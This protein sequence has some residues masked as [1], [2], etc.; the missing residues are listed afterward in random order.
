[1]RIIIDG[2]NV[3]KKMYHDTFIE[4]T[5][6]LKFL[7]ELQFYKKKKNHEILVVFDGGVFSYPVKEH[8]KD[9]IVIYP[10]ANRSADDYIEEYV[11]YKHGEQLLVSSDRELCSAVAEH[12]VVSIDAHI[13][14]ELMKE[15]ISPQKTQKKTDDYLRKLSQE[16]NITLDELMA[17]ASESLDYKPEDQDEFEHPKKLSKLEKK[18]YNLVK[19]L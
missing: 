8:Y 7:N 16:K 15:T 9:I 13:F 6:R 2:Y 19:K 3:L 1:M 14:Y 18:L 12:E 10:G 4:E 5:Q 17:E 11:S